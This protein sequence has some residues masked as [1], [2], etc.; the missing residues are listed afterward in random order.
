MLIQLLEYH[1]CSGLSDNSQDPPFMNAFIFNVVQHSLFRF[2][3][4]VM[5]VGVT[6]VVAVA[7]VVAVFM[8]YFVRM[9]MVM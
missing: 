4:V 1:I 6:V 7:V 5:R 2:V 8:I 3:A 9:V